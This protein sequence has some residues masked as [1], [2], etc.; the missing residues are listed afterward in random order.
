MFFQS[1]ELQIFWKKSIFQNKFVLINMIKKHLA[2]IPKLDVRKHLV[3]ELCERKF[4]CVKE[5]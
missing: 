3:H 5:A 4:G 2:I 1:V